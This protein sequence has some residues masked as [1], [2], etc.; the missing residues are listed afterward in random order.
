[1]LVNF[2]YPLGGSVHL[3]CT[4]SLQRHNL[5]ADWID[6]RTL[7]DCLPFPCERVLILE[8]DGSIKPLYEALSEKAAVAART[9][10]ERREST[11]LDY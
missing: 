1:M 5:Q 11:E 8:D 3:L 2:D 4:A 6:V 7:H 9:Q 10:E